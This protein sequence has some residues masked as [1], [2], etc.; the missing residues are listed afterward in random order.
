MIHFGDHVVI[1]DDVAVLV[2]DEA[3][4]DCSCR[5]G[6]CG[7]SLPEGPLRKKRRTA[8][9]TFIAVALV[10]FI[11]AP[12]RIVGG[13][14]SEVGSDIDDRRLQPFGELGELLPSCTALGT[15]A[16]RH[17]EPN[18][19]RAACTPVLSSVPITIPIASVTRT[20]LKDSSFC[21]RIQLNHRMLLFRLPVADLPLYLNRLISFWY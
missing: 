21:C 2:D 19:G 20:R 7:A 8:V 14:R 5:R 17:P 10:A 13:F 9:G 16:G 11:A 1:G 6:R 3:V 12:M 18:C 4:P 15:T